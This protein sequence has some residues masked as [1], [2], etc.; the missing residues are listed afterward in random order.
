LL[1][2]DDIVGVGAVIKVEALALQRNTVS[3]EGNREERVKDVVIYK[4]LQRS[5]SD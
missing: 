4:H 5:Y 3:A 2:E 1:T